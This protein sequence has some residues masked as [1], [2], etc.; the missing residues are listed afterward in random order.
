MQPYSSDTYC[1]HFY[2]Y[3]LV[4]YIIELWIQ[5]CVWCCWHTRNLVNTAAG[6]T[7]ILGLMLIF[8]RKSVKNRRHEITVCLL[9]IINPYFYKRKKK[10]IFP[11]FWIWSF[12][13][14]HGKFLVC[15]TYLLVPPARLL[16]RTWLWLNRTVLRS[17][18]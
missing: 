6:T 11:S 13:K 12:T 15:E 18:L 5:L 4:M 17:V 3:C 9:Y 1:I 7:N 14:K 16:A 8:W 2:C 10:Y